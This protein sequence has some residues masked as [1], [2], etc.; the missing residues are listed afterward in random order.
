MYSILHA[1]PQLVTMNPMGISASGNF[2]PGLNEGENFSPSFLPGLVHEH[3]VVCLLTDPQVAP[4]RA[5]MDL[6]RL[7]CTVAWRWAARFSPA[8][9]G[10]SP[11][12]Y[13]CRP[14]GAMTR[15]GVAV[16]GGNRRSTTWWASWRD[17]TRGPID[18]RRGVEGGARLGLPGDNR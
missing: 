13:G 14:L 1:H 16:G 4:A 10:V 6:A 5:H 8:P 7:L 15:T 18:E 3:G 9:D 11:W 12:A 2:L 17:P